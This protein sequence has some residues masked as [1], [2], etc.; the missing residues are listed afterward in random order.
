MRSFRFERARLVL[1][2]ALR[3][4]RRARVLRELLLRAH[5]AVQLRV[6]VR[7]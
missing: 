2:E 5:D 1:V 6:R 7:N 4:A 3:G